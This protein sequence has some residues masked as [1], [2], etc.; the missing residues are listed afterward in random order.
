MPRHVY[1]AIRPEA[2]ASLAQTIGT[3]PFLLKEWVP[4]S[5]LLFERNPNYW[6]EG[7]PYL[8]RIVM[9]I[10][11]SPTSP[12]RPGGSGPRPS[13]HLAPDVTGAT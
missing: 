12:P 13:R 6:D 2:S 4:G 1:E 5:H 9:R 11:G 10:S 8:D 7:K 3:G